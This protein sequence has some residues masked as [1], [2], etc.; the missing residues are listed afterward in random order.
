MRHE[1]GML[2]ADKGILMMLSLGFGQSSPVDQLLQPLGLCHQL[3]LGGR[4]G[5]RRFGLIALAII[6]STPGRRSD[7]FLPAG[8]GLG[9][10]AHAG[11]IGHRDRDLLLMQ[12]LDQSAFIATGGFAN[13]VNVGYLLQLSAQLAQAFQGIAELALLALQMKLQGSF[14]DIDT[15]IDDCGVGLHSFDRVLTHP[16]LYELTVLAAAPATVRVWSTGRA[17][18][19]LG[20]GLAQGRP[21]VARARARRDRPCARA[22]ASCSCLC[23]KSK[24]SKGTQ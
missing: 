18:L 17:R 4:G 12:E 1:L 9:P 14:G 22:P 3:V 19:W 6:E 24:R 13:H 15:G 23:K 2:P 16:Y 5:R 21:R 11:R 8:L 20:Y 10:G 7:R